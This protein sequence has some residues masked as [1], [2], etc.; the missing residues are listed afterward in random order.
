MSKNGSVPDVNEWDDTSE[1]SVIKALPVPVQPWAATVHRKV[2][3]MEWTLHPENDKGI[4][5]RLASIER[6]L[7]N[8]LFTLRAVPIL[9]AVLGGAYWIWQHLSLK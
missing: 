5:G 2:E 8:V 9:A 7:G 1:P 4:H 3:R 6:L